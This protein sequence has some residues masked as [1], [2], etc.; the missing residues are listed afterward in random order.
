MSHWKQFFCCLVLLTSPMAFAGPESSGGGDPDLGRIQEMKAS[1][2][3][4][5]KE[6]VIG[7]L[8]WSLKYRRDLKESEL[9]EQ[10]NDL[11][12]YLDFEEDVKKSDYVVLEDKPCID[13][14]GEPRAATSVMGDRNGPICFSAPLL[15]KAEMSESEFIAFVIHEHL[16]HFEIE[17]KDHAFMGALM[18]DTKRYFKALAERDEKSGYA[19]VPAKQR[20]TVEIEVSKN[21]TLELVISTCSHDV[22]VSAIADFYD[23]FGKPYIPGI[24]RDTKEK[25]TRCST[26]SI[27]LLQQRDSAYP[28]RGGVSIDFINSRTL[29]IDA[30]ASLLFFD[31]EGNAVYRTDRNVE[32][33]LSLR[34]SDTPI[35][36]GSL[37]VSHFL[38]KN[39]TFETQFAYRFVVKLKP[40]ELK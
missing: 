12:L 25:D 10:L 33:N 3:D 37:S 5:L 30:K 15:L 9:Q 14:Y 26:K 31:S 17:D 1:I 22:Q 36:N 24:L 2:E 13:K 28:S 6:K 21:D 19:H 7:Y 27:M 32:I 29:L 18:K 8:D 40:T 34:L 35:W 38:K 4:E 20:T 23:D 16:H 39:E 11:I